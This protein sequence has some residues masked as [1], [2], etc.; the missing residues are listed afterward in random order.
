MHPRVS[1]CLIVKNEEG[2]LPACLESAADLVDEVV[3]VDTGSTDR[4][5][6][7]A[8]RFGARVF[9]FPWVDDFAAARNE[10]VRHAIGDWIFWL[11]ADDR[12]D[13]ENRGRL[14]LLLAGLKDEDVA[15]VMKCACLNGPAGNVSLIDHVRLFRNRPGARWQNRVH[16]QIRGSL[17]QLHYAIRQADVE[18]LHV[19]YQDPRVQ[20]GK[21][22]RNLRL[23][24]KEDAEHPH[25]PY[26]QFNIGW[27]YQGLDRLAEAQT[28]YR[29]SLA[30]LGTERPYYARKL[31]GMLTR[32]CRQLGQTAD[33]MT[34]CQEG[35]SLYPDDAELL[36]QEAWLLYLFGDYAGTESRLLQLVE[37]PGQPAS[38][39]NYSDDPGLRGHVTRHNLA[40]LYRDQGRLAEAEAQW[41]AALAEQPDFTVARLGLGELYLREGRWQELEDVLARLQADPATQVQAAV[42][43]AQKHLALQDY[44]AAHRLADEAIAAD[45]RA[46]GP[47]IVLSR[48]LLAEGSD[49]AVIAQAL[50]EVLALDPNNQEAR[51][52]LAAM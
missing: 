48:V 50:R 42:L 24:L 10:A 52:N 44:P 38:Y 15:Y 39:G 22:G 46:P 14:R 40:V 19:G 12:L 51:Q 26:T 25:D 9:D 49:R 16:E 21:C 18:I 23:L 7:V 33:A 28:Y 27:A 1:L 43:L 37:G 4:T 35:R 8:A 31:Y 41:R 36:T 45:P 2:N 3:V 11:D 32:V 34:V 20:K 29:R 6:E 47:R 30:L 5:R 13:E 17:D